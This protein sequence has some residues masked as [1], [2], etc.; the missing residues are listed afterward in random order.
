MRI[1]GVKT[2]KEIAEEYNIHPT[3]LDR[4]LKE[5]NFLFNSK[6][7]HKKLYYPNEINIIYERL[8]NPKP[9]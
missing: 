7:K 2:R 1:G 8:G 6:Q 5:F 4:R 9:Q 3:T